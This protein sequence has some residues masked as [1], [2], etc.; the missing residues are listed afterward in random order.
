MRKPS[1][2]ALLLSVSLTG[3]SGSI[4]GTA[5]QVCQTWQIVTISKD[6]KL[7]DQTA[8]EIA[9]NNAARQTWCK[10]QKP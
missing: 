5:S 2:L 6:D 1:A 7:T 8:K 4:A 10:D 3:C 9:G